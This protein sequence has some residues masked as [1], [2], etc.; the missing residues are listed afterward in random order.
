MNPYPKDWAFQE[1]PNSN[2][3]ANTL[4]GKMNLYICSDFSRSSN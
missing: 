4:T 1:A 2:P 3:E